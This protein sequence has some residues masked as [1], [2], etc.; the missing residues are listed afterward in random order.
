MIDDLK[1]FEELANTEV[2]QNNEALTS[3]I[4]LKRQAKIARRYKLGLVL[5]SIITIS[6]AIWYTQRDIVI[7]ELEIEGNLFTELSLI[8]KLAKPTIG[9]NADS[10][11]IIGLVEEI[12][13]LAY[14]K[15]ASLYVEPSGT[16][17]IFITERKPI[18]W[19]VDGNIFAIVDAE[20]VIMPPTDIFLDIPLLHGYSA[21]K[22][23][24]GQLTSNN[25]KQLSLF[26]TNLQN[27]PFSNA[28][29]SEVVYNNEYGVTA[30]SNDNGVKISF[31]TNEFER[32]LA[33]WK[34]FHSQIV[35]FKGI[36]AFT[37]VDLR[38]PNQIITREV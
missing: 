7:D 11:N 26:L 18:A 31:G 6:F 4:T 16:L 3:E 36:Q 22:Y 27:D 25:F 2:T 29:I 37:E 21:N 30:L 5:F 33:T 12:Q 20:G 38:F 24:K 9:T 1:H 15:E 17:R 32:K 23:Q 13:K 28:T 10:L 14:I 35:K 19:L 8:E 34:L